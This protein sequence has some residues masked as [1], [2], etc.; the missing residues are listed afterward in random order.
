[1]LIWLFGSVNG[2][3]VYHS[4][5]KRV[6]GLIE[7]EHARVCWYLSV[8]KND[9][10]YAI[11][12]S[13]RTTFRSII[14]DGKEVEFSEGFSNLHTRVYEETLAGRGFRIKDARPSIELTYAIRFAPI[15]S[16]D[17]IV[18]PLLK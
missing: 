15:S 9:L 8:E 17:K 18:H 13:G 11:Q 12:L 16:K 1:L 5:E 7:L 3:K 10:P 14:V 4:D 2:L 6:S